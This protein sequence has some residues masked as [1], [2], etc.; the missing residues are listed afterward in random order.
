MAITT[1]SLFKAVL[2]DRKPSKK[3]ERV[4]VEAKARTLVRRLYKDGDVETALR[5]AERYGNAAYAVARKLKWKALL[6]PRIEDYDLILINTSAGKDSQTTMRVVVELAK[7]KGILDRVYAV[8]ADLGRMDWEGTR[9]LAIKQAEHYGIPIEIIKRPQGDL[10]TH[11]ETRGKFPSSACRYCT[12]DHKRGQVVKVVTKLSN[13]LGI[14]GRKVRVLNCMGIRAE[15]SSRR[16]TFSPFAFDSF[17]SNK[18]KRTSH[19]WYPI[20]EMSTQEVWDD[21]EKSGVPHHWAYDI[22]M[23]RLS[24]NFCFF[25]GTDALIVSGHHNQATLK[26]LVRIEKKIGHTFKHKFAIAEVLDAV[27]RG[28][29]PTLDPNMSWVD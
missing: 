7:K 29:M 27:K 2:V 11:I 8:H 14:K 19:K 1:K 12:S 3:A 5:V 25:V 18:T 16:A 28:E 21:I 20:F 4:K 23:P 24:C 17:N 13:A 22:G 6:E 26:E 9:E 10:P 15:E